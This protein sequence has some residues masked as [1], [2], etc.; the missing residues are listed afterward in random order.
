M[1]LQAFIIL[2][3]IKNHGKTKGSPN[4]LIKS[5][6]NKL[7]AAQN[8]YF[9]DY[10]LRGGAKNC[11]DVILADTLSFQRIFDNIVDST[12]LNNIKLTEIALPCGYSTPLN[13]FAVAEGIDSYFFLATDFFK[14]YNDINK[15]KYRWKN[16]SQIKH[17]TL[18]YVR[19][20]Q[21]SREDSSAYIIY[22]MKQLA[23]HEELKRLLEVE[24]INQSDF[25]SL[26]A[27][28]LN[29]PIKGYEKKDILYALV[30]NPPTE[31]LE[32]LSLKKNERIILYKKIGGAPYLKTYGYFVG[33][34]LNELEQ[35]IE[36]NKTI[37]ILPKVIPETNDLE[38]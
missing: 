3:C 18:H 27:L 9:Q 24:R 16:L 15:N 2:G 25:V 34:V 38:M 5:E 10:H 23:W 12:R 36:L 33:F 21:Y 32:S 29:M 6:L 26:C 37:L 8:D 7:S 11:L 19:E 4:E 13:Y 1:L 28:L 31:L 22:D 14:Y 20:V 35:R 17:D 30:N